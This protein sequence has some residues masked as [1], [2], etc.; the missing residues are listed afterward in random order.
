MRSDVLSKY[1]FY[2]GSLGLP[3]LWIV[4]VL[5]FRGNQ[6]SGEGLINPEDHFHDE[7]VTRSDGRSAQEINDEAAKWVNRCQKG[8]TI[9]VVMWIG[10]IVTS[11]VLRSQGLLPSVLFFESAY[12]TEVTGW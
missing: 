11:Q 9:A 6:E 3:W 10:W 7:P 5:Y 1:M 8:A 4:H 12:N 2:V